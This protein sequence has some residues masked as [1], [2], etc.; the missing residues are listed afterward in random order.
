MWLFYLHENHPVSI[1]TQNIPRTPG[2][3]AGIST[4]QHAEKHAV[5]RVIVNE[6]LSTGVAIVRELRIIW[7]RSSPK[8]PQGR[9]RN[10]R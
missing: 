7:V 4:V 9:H 10:A 5:G 2:T 3:S 8:G 1:A 6:Y